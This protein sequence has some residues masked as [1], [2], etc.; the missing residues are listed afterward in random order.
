M[1]TIDNCDWPAVECGYA[2]IE[3]IDNRR[4]WQTMSRRVI[5]TILA[6]QVVVI[7]SILAGAVAQVVA[8]ALGG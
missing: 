5:G 1:K 4:R 8:R 7:A 3:Y 2:R 6:V